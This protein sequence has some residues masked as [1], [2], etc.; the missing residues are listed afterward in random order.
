MKFTRLRAKARNVLRRDRGATDPI[1]VIAAIAVSLIL[2]VGGS[3][4]V[5]GMINNGKDLNAKS[6]LDKI[7]TAEAASQS[8]STGSYLSWEITAAGV[9]TVD[10]PSGKDLSKG[11][12]GF[13]PSDGEAIKVAANANGWVAGVKSTTGKTFY[14]TS[15]SSKIYDVVPTGTAIPTGVTVPTLP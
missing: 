2:L 14:R 1:L 11:D 10:T 7:A 3:F 9:P 4:A 13:T 8:G 12:V 6:D 15:T 5:A